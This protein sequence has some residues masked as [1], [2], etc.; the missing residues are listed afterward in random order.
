MLKEK[1]E[2]AEA[3]KYW[4][5]CHNVRNNTKD[6]KLKILSSTFTSKKSYRSSKTFG[7]PATPVIFGC[8]VQP[9]CTRCLTYFCRLRWNAFINIQLNIFYFDLF[10]DT[11]GNVQGP[12]PH[13]KQT[14]TTLITG[15]THQ[16]AKLPLHPMMQP[17]VEN[18]FNFFVQYGDFRPR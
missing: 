18:F 16:Y 6:K 3:Q 10:L 8:L 11:Q 15:R 2:H 12:P 5:M 13:P 4:I 9:S 7:I 1:N 14:R 17:V